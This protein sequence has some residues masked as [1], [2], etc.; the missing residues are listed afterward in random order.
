MY[1][2]DIRTIVLYRK[3]DTG[4]KFRE[5]EEI[6]LITALPCCTDAKALD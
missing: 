3:E 2:L 1:F 5:Q 4:R 6:A